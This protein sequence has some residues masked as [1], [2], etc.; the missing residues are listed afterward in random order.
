MRARHLPKLWLMTDERMGEGLWAVLERVPRGGGVVFRHY[1]TP[2][3]E[4]RR[5]FARVMRIARRRGLVVVRAGAL[6][7]RGEQGVHNGLK[8][9]GLRTFAVHDRPQGVAARR[10]GAD[11]VFVSPVFVTRSHPGARGLG[12]V[13]LGLLLCG[14]EVPAV[15]LGGMDARRFRR[16]QG[17][18]LWGWA[19]IDAWSDPAA[20]KPRRRP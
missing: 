18:G 1:A 6:A 14:L 17:L 20:T 10:V 5:L 13:R 16:L 7:M 3:A 15:A 12:A 4:R 8:G 9:R 19:A 2:T 11:L